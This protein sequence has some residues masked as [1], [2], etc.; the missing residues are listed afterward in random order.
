LTSLLELW[1]YNATL[2]NQL[3]R[4]EILDAVNSATVRYS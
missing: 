1:S 3:N 2:I 4:S